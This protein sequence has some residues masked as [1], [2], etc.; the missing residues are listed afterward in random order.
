MINIFC[1]LKLSKLLG[2][3]KTVEINSN[4][5]TDWSAHIF[6]IA[7]KK[8]LIFVNKHTLYSVIVMNVLKKDMNNL[9]ILFTESLIRQL[10]REKILTTN[11]ENYLREF[12]QIANI[13]T[14]DNDRKTMGSINDFI[15]HTK[16]CYEDDRTIEKAKNFALHY[17]NTVPSKVLK[18]STPHEKMKELIKSYG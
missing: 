18:Y 17:V 1:S 7:G 4:F 11:F 3:E 14:T 16:S 6:S 5:E 2:I 9:S 10:D 8:W 13:C 15:F 12:D